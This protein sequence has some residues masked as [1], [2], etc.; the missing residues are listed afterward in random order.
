MYQPPNMAAGFLIRWDTI[1]KDLIVAHGILT[2][3]AAVAGIALDG[4]DNAVFAFFHDAD[5]IG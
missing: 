5:M 3:S 2:L 1:S 4:V